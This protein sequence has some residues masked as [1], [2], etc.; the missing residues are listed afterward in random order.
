MKIVN[1]IQGT[2]LGGMEQASLSLM[3]GLKRL[4]HTLS[5]ISLNPIGSLGPLLLEN[6]IAAK[7]LPYL[8]RAGWRSFFLLRDALRNSNADALIMTGH[9]FFSMVA[10]GNF[11]KHKRILAVHFHHAGVKPVW[12]WRLIYML[13]CLRFKAVTFPSDFVREEAETIYP[14]LKQRSHTL[15]NPISIPVLP[16]EEEKVSSRRAIG[17]P[18]DIFVIGNAGWLTHRKRF[19]IFLR[20]AQKVLEA[21]PKTLFLIAGDGE[22][23]ERL[24]AL[25]EQLGIAEHIQWLG[26]QENLSNFYKCLDVMLFNSDWDAMGL[27]PLEAV[28]FGVPLVASVRHGGLAEIIS[29]ERYGFLIGEHDIELLAEKVIFFLENPVLAREVALA[30]RQRI[31]EISDPQKIVNETVALL[32]A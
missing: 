4:G 32:M 28:T 18:A 6:R 16:I 11:C 3:I 24:E 31:K 15:R 20:V 13:A 21:V 14:A 1:V 9:H 27:S 7:G 22:E 25:A 30:G 2:N 17:V 26:W 29:N 8:G 12:Q 10:L 19:D 5:I 23:R